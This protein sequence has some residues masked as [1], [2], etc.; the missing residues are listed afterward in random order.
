MRFFLG[1]VVGIVLVAATVFAY[2]RF[3]NLPVAADDHPMPLERWFSHSA[4]GERIDRDA[5]KAPIAADDAVYAAGAQ[6]Y[7]QNCAVC[8]GVPDHSVWMASH[9]FPKAPQL[10]VR[11]EDGVVGVSDDPAGETYWKVANGIRLSGMP[12]FKDTLSTTEMWQVSL[13]L[14]NADKLP[15]DVVTQ[16]QKPVA[17]PLEQR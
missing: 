2:L 3:G 8:H 16:L 15:V 6:I 10:F 14:A 9:M 4:L 5:Q 11:H 1:V 13:L 17:A 12:A 7:T